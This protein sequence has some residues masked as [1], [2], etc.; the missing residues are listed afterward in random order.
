MI[1]LFRLLISKR[2]AK[3]RDIP[4]WK[5]AMPIP[6][7]VRASIGVFRRFHE[8]Q[9]KD[10]W[11]VDFEFV[12]VSEY[13]PVPTQ[14]AIRLL[15]GDLLLRTNINYDMSLA[16]FIEKIAQVLTRSHYIGEGFLN[17]YRSNETNGLRPLEIRN[18]IL[19]LGYSP[20]RTQILSWVS[21]QDMQCFQRLLHEGNELLVPRHSHTEVRNFQPVNVHLICQRLFPQALNLKLQSVHC[22][23]TKKDYGINT[24]YYHDAGNDTEALVEIIQGILKIA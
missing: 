5:H 6:E 8:H 11:V 22:G 12:S 2:T 1:Q 20:E 19:E 3:W 7:N 9:L 15:N 21:A 13:S 14:I 17:S 18:K 4:E 16:V 23:L 24:N 10:L